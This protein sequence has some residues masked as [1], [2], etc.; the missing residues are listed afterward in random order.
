MAE[1][2]FFFP[3]KILSFY[4]TFSIR[5]FKIGLKL[6]KYYTGRKIK[7]LLNWD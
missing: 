1:N 7:E 4:K 5:G 3:Q 2:L 6:D